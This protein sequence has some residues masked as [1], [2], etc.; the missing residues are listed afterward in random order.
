MFNFEFIFAKLNFFDTPTVL[1]L[2]ELILFGW[3]G[4]YYYY[5]DFLHNIYGY[6]NYFAYCYNYVKKLS[7]FFYIYVFFFS[8]LYG[9]L[10]LGTGGGLL[11]IDIF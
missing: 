8:L 10:N 4:C 1:L 9:R 3:F 7:N 2:V 5:T 6:L 11:L